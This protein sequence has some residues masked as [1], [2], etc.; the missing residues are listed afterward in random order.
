M[1]KSLILLIILALIGAS[2]GEKITKHFFQNGKEKEMDMPGSERDSEWQGSAFADII[3]AEPYLNLLSHSVTQTDS[4]IN[5]MI[6]ERLSAN[7]F[8]VDNTAIGYAALMEPHFLPRWLDDGNG[9]C[10]EGDNRFLDVLDSLLH[11]GGFII[12]AAGQGEE[13]TLDNNELEVKLIDTLQVLSN[14][15]LPEGTPPEF[16]GCSY[17]LFP[18]YT[19]PEHWR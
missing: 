11:V 6:L 17:S 19:I 10:A 14:E 5:S 3:A 4:G 18:L 15:P 2:Y 8:D 7:Q 13:D 16:S 9:E 1:K 12:N